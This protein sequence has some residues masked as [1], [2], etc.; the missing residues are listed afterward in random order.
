MS[1]SVM[2]NL[3]GLGLLVLFV[4]SLTKALGHGNNTNSPSHGNG[5]SRNSSLRSP[6][7]DG[8]K[9]LLCLFAL[10]LQ[11]AHSRSS[12]TSDSGFT[13]LAFILVFLF[14]P[15]TAK[16]KLEEMNYVCKRKIPVAPI[17]PIMP[18]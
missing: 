16:P 2:I 7:P 10:V 1:F 5:T 8:E 14:V 15:S 13:A 12:L 11:L 4:P 9:N 3:L 17:L 6:N 18:N